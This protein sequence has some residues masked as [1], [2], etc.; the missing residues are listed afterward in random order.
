MDNSFL[1]IREKNTDDKIALII[2]FSTHPEKTFTYTELEQHMKKLYTKNFRSE[3]LVNQLEN[4]Q[5]SL[6]I[7]KI[8]IS[9][10]R[11]G[12][13][14]NLTH[15]ANYAEKLTEL[16][17]SILTDETTKAKDKA[18]ILIDHYVDYAFKLYKMLVETLDVEKTNRFAE[19]ANAI[20]DNLIYDLSL[21][22]NDDDRND[23]CNTLMKM[24]DRYELVV[25]HRI[26]ENKIEYLKEKHLPKS[27]NLNRHSKNSNPSPST[28]SEPNPEEKRV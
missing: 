5:A 21:L 27:E 16:K 23:F 3:R 8:K 1:N 14:F 13:Q 18:E 9:N 2:L 11:Y 15:L 10:R 26:E 24:L 12:Y 25:P 17:N 22:T 20:R 6:T 4:L 19:G 28:T 7:K